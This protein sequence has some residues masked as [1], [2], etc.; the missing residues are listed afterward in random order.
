MRHFSASEMSFGFTGASGFVIE[1]EAANQLGLSSFG[2]FHCSGMMDN[3]QISFRRAN[4]ISLGP[5]TIQQPLFMEMQLG[6]LVRGGPGD[7]IG[8]AG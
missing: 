1:A 2:R 8:I 4:T 3:V 7:V 6:G 5:L